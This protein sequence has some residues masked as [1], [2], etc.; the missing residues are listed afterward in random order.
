MIVRDWLAVA[1]AEMRTG[2]ATLA[3]LLGE[4]ICT[5]TVV[6]KRGKQIV[7]T[8]NKAIDCNFNLEVLSR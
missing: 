5:V 8:R 2:D 6:A 1:L 3:A 4:V 7:F